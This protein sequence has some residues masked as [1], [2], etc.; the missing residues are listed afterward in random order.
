[1]LLWQI[2]H[3]SMVL[4]CSKLDLTQ[5]LFFSRRTSSNY[6]LIKSL[7]DNHHISYITNIKHSYSSHQKQSCSKTHWCLLPVNVQNFYIIAKFDLFTIQTTIHNTIYTSILTT[8]F[9]LHHPL[10]T[11]FTSIHTINNTTLTTIHITINTTILTT[12]LTQSLTAL[13]TIIW[14]IFIFYFSD[15]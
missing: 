8:I 7:H 3:V 6:I 1:M 11:I 9:T 14:K 13:Q 2:Q 5:A 4:N 15:L 10:T 12:N